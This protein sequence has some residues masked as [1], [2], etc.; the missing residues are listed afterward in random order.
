[1]KPSYVDDINILL[2][3]LSSSAQPCTDEWLSGMFDSGTKLF[4]ALDNDKI[5]GTVL[6]CTMVILVGRKDWIEDVVVDEKYRRR[7]IATVF[8][9]MA[10]SVSRRR[11]AKSINLTSNPER[12]GARQM[13]GDM[14][15]EVRDTG[16]FRLTF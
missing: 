14:G 8:M 10:H 12:G 1:M 4:V 16:V 5:I 13:Y 6:L 3:Q 7:G 11:D 15:Y 9:D 2:P